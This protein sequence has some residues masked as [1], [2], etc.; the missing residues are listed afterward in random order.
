M[1]TELQKVLQA[2]SPNISAILCSLIAAVDNSQETV[3]LPHPFSNMSRED[4]TRCIKLWK[5]FGLPLLE[6]QPART[7]PTCDGAQSRYMFQSFDAYPYHEC[8]ACGTWYVPLKIDY[9]LFKRYFTIVPEARRFGDYTESQITN[10]AATSGDMERFSG[11]YEVLKALF[12]AQRAAALTACDIGCGVGNSIEA[13]R[14]HGI[15]GVGL[16]VNERA[17]TVAKDLGRP[18]FSAS[19]NLPAPFDIVSMWETLEHIDDALAVL[20]LAHSLLKEGGVLAITVPNL[21]APSIRGMREDSLQIHGGPAWAGHINLFSPANIKILLE[22]AGFEILDLCGQYNSNLAELVGYQTGVWRGARDYASGRSPKFS[23][24]SAANNL[25]EFLGPGLAEIERVC[26]FAPIMRVLAVRK[27]DT[28]DLRQQSLHQR[29]LDESQAHMAAM[30]GAPAATEPLVRN[31]QEYDLKA[32]IY[33]DPVVSFAPGGGLELDGEPLSRFSY[34]WKSAPVELTLGQQVILR[35]V[36]RKGGLTIGLLQGNEWA[37]SS[38]PCPEM[39]FS[40]S[41]A[42][43]TAGTFEIAISFNMTEA[44]EVS[45]DLDKM[46]IA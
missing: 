31:K 19:A 13:A 4:W 1:K 39:P 17:L 20:E 45:I 10:P 6:E 40:I 32:A 21:N 3:Q 36:A 7:C 16:E 38:Q 44:G 24:S 27:A 29:R 15:S 12:P 33:V 9:E 8:D 42:A 23:I 43:P 11:Y 46:Y 41:V 14:K 37:A 5:R 34:A 2:N 35:G 30:Y 18:V 28:P 26:S 22:R 25:I